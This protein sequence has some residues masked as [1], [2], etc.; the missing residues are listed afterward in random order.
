MDHTPLPWYEEP[1]TV[2]G[3]HRILADVG[4]IQV[5]PCTVHGKADVDL[6][7]RSVN[8]HHR[9]IAALDL[10]Y[11][12]CCQAGW[13]DDKPQIMARAFNALRAAG[14]R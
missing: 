13:D 5:C 12:E 8:S 11:A 14:V 9:L 4:P 7:L 3:A 1:L 6:I 10:L 2:Q